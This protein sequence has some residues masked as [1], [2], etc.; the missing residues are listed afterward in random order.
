MLKSFSTN[1]L[2]QPKFSSCTSNKAF[3]REGQWTANEAM[4]DCAQNKLMF[5]NRNGEEYEFTDDKEET[6]SHPSWSSL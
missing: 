1:F 6:G 5:K 2:V 4:K 3:G